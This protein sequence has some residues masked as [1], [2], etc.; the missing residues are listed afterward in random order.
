MESSTK[1]GG[2]PEG[3]PA[4]CAVKCRKGSQVATFPNSSDPWHTRFARERVPS[5]PYRVVPRWRV[6]SVT[7][8]MRGW[9][10][11][12][13]HDGGTR[14]LQSG[15]LLRFLG[16]STAKLVPNR[17]FECE[18]SMDTLEKRP[19]VDPQFLRPRIQGHLF[20]TVGIGRFGFSVRPT[21]AGGC[22]SGTRHA[23]SQPTTAVVRP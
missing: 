16:K 5:G 19:I 14:R 1:M 12:A 23:P 18:P 10:S 7:A 13:H 15:Q 17:F 6:G 21:R 3:I 9:A 11:V 8:A 20:A 2:D 22:C 4:I